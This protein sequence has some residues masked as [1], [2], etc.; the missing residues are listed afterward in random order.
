MAQTLQDGC[1]MLHGS[2]GGIHA[3]QPMLNE[4]RL[5]SLHQ[6]QGIQALKI[7]RYGRSLSTTTAHPLLSRTCERGVW[8]PGCCDDLDR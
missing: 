3:Q 4:D 5:R 7:D 8:T 2:T 6:D 1:P